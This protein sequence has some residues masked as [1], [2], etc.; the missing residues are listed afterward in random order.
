[1][2][3][4][5]SV[6]HHTKKQQQKKCLS[7]ERVHIRSCESAWTLTPHRETLVLSG[8][9][10][11]LWRD[12]RRRGQRKT[13][14]C[15]PKSQ[16]QEGCSHV[17]GSFCE[18]GGKSLNDYINRVEFGVCVRFS[19]SFMTLYLEINFHVALT[20]SFPF[21]FWVKQVHHGKMGLLDWQV[22]E[23]ITPHGNF[24]KN[25]SSFL[26]SYQ[27]STYFPCVTTTVWVS[28]LFRLRVPVQSWGATSRDGLTSWK[29]RNTWEIW[30]S[31]SL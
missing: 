23:W 22:K 26:Y 8:P 4:V 30:A 14:K 19:G 13:C 24:D 11:C 20:V 25:S 3:V 16:K 15:V 27:L 29:T 7:S 6:S 31:W 1:M 9:E 10:N 18:L 2:D 12:R 5:L 17:T 28:G 21:Q